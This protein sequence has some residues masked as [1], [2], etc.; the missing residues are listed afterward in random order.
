[1]IAGN[2]N[3]AWFIAYTEQNTLSN[4]EFKKAYATA[5]S[6]FDAIHK[7]VNDIAADVIELA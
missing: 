5:I 3:V 4:T 1:M 7:L 2:L 6:K